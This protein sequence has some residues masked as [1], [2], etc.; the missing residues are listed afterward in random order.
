MSKN[1]IML[2]DDNFNEEI[3][4]GVVLVDFFAEWCNPCKMLGPIIEQLANEVPNEVKI[5][6]VNIDLAE[7]TTFSYN[8][9]SVPTIMIFKDGKPIQVKVGFTSKNDLIS[10][11]SNVLESSIKT[12]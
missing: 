6:K 9:M 12:N 3:K 10:I 2:N 11:I 8:V 7:K 4:N 5:C 1:V